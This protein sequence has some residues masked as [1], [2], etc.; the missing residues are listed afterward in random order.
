M[1][2][3]LQVSRAIDAF[4]DRL[5]RV[6]MWLVL[7]AVLVSA[8][9]A[10]VRKVFHAG[11]NSLLE[12]QWYLFATVFMLGGGYAFLRNA[13]VRIDFVSSRLGARARHWVDVVGIVVCVLPLCA[14]MW[15]LGWPLLVQAWVSG[16]VSS[17]AG[18]LPRWPIYALIP[19]GFAVL[20]LQAV[21]EL[22][23]RL[24]FLWG[25]GR[26]VLAHPEAHS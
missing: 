3:F 8:G 5:G 19:G 1:S 26:D 13:H 24:H 17:N 9:N 22:I 2:F 14:L 12:V 4:N 20:G 11:S 18:G 16:E 15:Q 21:S 6:L 7:L 23:K 25:T 10:L